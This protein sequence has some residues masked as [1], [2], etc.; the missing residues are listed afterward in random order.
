ML[1]RIDVDSKKENYSNIWSKV[2]NVNGRYTEL[3]KIFQDLIDAVDEYNPDDPNS[4]TAV[5]AA[6][7]RV[8]DR[9]EDGANGIQS[10]T[11]IEFNF[12]KDLAAITENIS[13]YNSYEPVDYSKDVSDESGWGSKNDNKS[14]VLSTYYD[15]A[16]YVD[17]FENELYDDMIPQINYLAY[18]INNYISVY[19][20]YTQFGAMKI[21]SEP[22][23]NNISVDKNDNYSPERQKQARIDELWNN[24]NET[25]YKAMR[26]L[27]QAISLYDSKL[28]GAMRSYDT[29][30]VLYFNNVVDSVTPANMLGIRDGKIRKTYTSNR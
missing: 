24:Y 26:A 25:Y 3:Y 1:A 21:Y 23:S 10:H 2:D 16:T 28:E 13:P 18:V 7:N 30:S 19:K 29:Q 17:A 4:L 11:Q 22:A 12:P 27:A 5:Q 9:Y 8:N 14:T 15:L 20:L 6:Y